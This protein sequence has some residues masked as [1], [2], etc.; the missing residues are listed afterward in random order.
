[1]APSRLTICLVSKLRSRS[2]AEGNCTACIRRGSPTLDATSAAFSPSSC[3]DC[4]A[5]RV[6]ASPLSGG[7]VEGRSWYRLMDHSLALQERLCA[8]EWRWRN[9]LQPVLRRLSVGFVPLVELLD[10]R[11]DELFLQT[12]AHLGQEFLKLN[13]E[14]FSPGPKLSWRLLWRRTARCRNLWNSELPTRLTVI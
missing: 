11:L 5:V 8:D 13:T 10:L 12:K 6:A 1:M 9:S 3:R 14:P 4:S 2:R 7:N